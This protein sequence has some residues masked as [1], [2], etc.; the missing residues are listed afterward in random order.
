MKIEG[1]N[2]KQYKQVIVSPVMRY[3]RGFAKG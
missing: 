1:N 2:K 3:R